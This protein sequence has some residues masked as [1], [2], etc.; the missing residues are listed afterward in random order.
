MLDQGGVLDG[1]YGQV[2]E[3]NDLLIKSAAPSILKNGLLTVNLLNKLVTHFNYRIVFHS[4][5][6]EQDQIDLLILLQ[7]ACKEKNVEFPPVYAMAVYDP[8]KFKEVDPTNPK[9]SRVS[10]ILVTGYGIDGDGKSCVR[11][12]LSTALGIAE[13]QRSQC[14]VFD[15][16]PS[17]IAKAEKEGYSCYQISSPTSLYE[18]CVS[19]L[20]KEESNLSQSVARLP[21]TNLSSLLANA[22]PRNKVVF[23]PRVIDSSCTLPKNVSEG[24]LIYGFQESRAIMLEKLKQAGKDSTYCVID[25]Y[26]T[27]TRQFHSVL[28]DPEFN[29][30]PFQRAASN[31]HDFSKIFEGALHDQSYYYKQS[32]GTFYA[33]E[34]GISDDMFINKRCKIGILWALSQGRS[35]HFILDNI[36]FEQCFDKKLGVKKYTHAELRFIYRHWDQLEKYYTEGRL[37]FYSM[38]DGEYRK[39]AVPWENTKLVEAYQ[40]K[41]S[42]VELY[43]SF[44][45][46]L[47]EDKYSNLPLEF[48]QFLSA[49]T[50]KVRHEL[51]HISVEDYWNGLRCEQKNGLRK[52]FQNSDSPARANNNNNPTSSNTQAGSSSICNIM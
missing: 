35:I 2:L 10:D 44:F 13:Q 28:K 4:K 39:V 48:R 1:C 8:N 43:N 46:S 41:K 14:V 45:T 18:A 3:S 19:I 51:Q 24:D 32:F 20:K 36:N 47:N 7:Q 38:V 34:K 52:E 15:D 17:V 9:I 31:F 11:K 40:P 12:A 6:R 25:I 37:N 22:Q 16:G 33:Q 21:V 29:K 30:T 5:N 50:Q 42:K 26:N 27:F 49:T 23:T